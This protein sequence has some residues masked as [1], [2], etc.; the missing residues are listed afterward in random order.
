MFYDWDEDLWRNIMTSTKTMRVFDFGRVVATPGV[1]QALRSAQVTA[2]ELL[3]R[4]AAPLS[5]I[6]ASWN[7]RRQLVG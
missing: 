3:R 5:N 6:R 2:H 4:Q 7:W 1:L